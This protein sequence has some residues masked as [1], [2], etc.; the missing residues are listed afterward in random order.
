MNIKT[1]INKNISVTYNEG[2]IDNSVRSDDMVLAVIF[3]MV[4]DKN[5]RKKEDQS[6]RFLGSF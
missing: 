5:R 1:A 3:L 4:D 6:I 2:L